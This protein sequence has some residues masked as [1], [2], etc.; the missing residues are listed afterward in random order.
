M[1]HFDSVYARCRRSLADAT[2]AF[3]SCRRHRAALLYATSTP[4]PTHITIRRSD[5]SSNCLGN[6]IFRCF[7]R[8]LLTVT[9]R[10]GLTKGFRL[11]NRYGR[12]RSAKNIRKNM[13]AACAAYEYARTSVGRRHRC[14]AHSCFPP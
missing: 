10:Y 7:R 2:V 13:V 6:K 4:P 9:E 8:F 3:P 12:L 1:I 11:E 14:T 5:K